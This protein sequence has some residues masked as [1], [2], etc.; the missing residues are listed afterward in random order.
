MSTTKTKP[1]PMALPRNA[2]PKKPAISG[3]IP[4]WKAKIDAHIKENPKYWDYIQA[5]PRDRLE[6]TV[7][8]NEVR[9]T[10]YGRMAEKHWR[11]HR[12]KMVRDLERKG[13]AP[14]ASGGGGKDEGRNGHAANGIDEAGING[15]AGADRRR[16]KWCGRNTSSCRPKRP[17]QRPPNGHQ[18]EPPKNLNSYRITEAD[19][20]GEGGPKQ[21]FQKN[22]AAIETLRQLDAEERPARRRKKPRW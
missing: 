9:L 13:L 10:Q 16:G 20:L 12:P 14:D 5:M 18:E 2:A 1:A 3:P 15:A 4:K 11:E 8:L 21:K 17:S 22:I 7:V 6:R 19:R